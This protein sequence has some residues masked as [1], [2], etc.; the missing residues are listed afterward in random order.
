MR[1]R[2][3]L[4]GG[5]GALV[6]IVAAIVTTRHG[7]TPPEQPPDDNSPKPVASAAPSNVN[8]EKPAI[9]P[10]H[11]VVPPRPRLEGKPCTIV[12]AAT[13]VADWADPSV[14]PAFAAIPGSHRVAVGLAQSDTY[15]IG[16]TI[17]PRTLDR[18]QVFREFRGPKLVSVV[19]TTEQGK[20]HFQVVREGF[21]LANARAVDGTVPFF[22]GE[23]ADGIARSVGKEPPAAIWSFPEANQSTVP[24][25]ATVPGVGHAVTFRRGGKS[26]ETVA[27]WLEPSGTKKT[28]LVGI[29]ADGDFAG[30]PTIA[31]GE[32]SVVIAFASRKADGPAW[33]VALALAKYGEVPTTAARFALPPGGPGGDAMSPALGA[34]P[35]GRWLLHWTEGSSGSRVARAEV[36]ARDLTPLSDPVNLSPEGANA[37]QGV[38][39]TNGDVGAVLFYVQNDKKSHE[40]WGASVECPR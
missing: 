22:L 40:L 18:D 9:A 10:A 21:P 15:A 32:D 37:G 28:E 16:I 3:A 36:L 38:V 39:W 12:T 4:A 33:N 24:R 8:V 35:G 27:G 2:M 31:A 11:V 13:R 29:K 19:P 26:G 20:L 34:L 25:I 5:G 14:V 7:E 23:T 1:R 6:L 17:D 30:T